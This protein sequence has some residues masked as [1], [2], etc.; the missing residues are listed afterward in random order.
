M[1]I[2]MNAYCVPNV[3]AGGEKPDGLTLNFNLNILL[4]VSVS[5]SA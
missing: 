4:S 5:V 2:I 1:F 3:G